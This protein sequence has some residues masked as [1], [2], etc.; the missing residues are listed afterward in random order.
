MAE[1]ILVGIKL[2]FGTPDRPVTNEEFKEFWMSLTS[3]E[4]D[5]MKAQFLQITSDSE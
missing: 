5:E 1:N 3:D 4:K 2:F